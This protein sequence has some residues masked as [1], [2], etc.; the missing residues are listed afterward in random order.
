MTQGPLLTTTYLLGSEG[1]TTEPALSCMGLQSGRSPWPPTTGYGFPRTSEKGRQGLCCSLNLGPAPPARSQV[2][3]T[4]ELLQGS[5]R[6]PLTAAPDQAQE[7]VLGS[8]ILDT[9]MPSLLT[10]HRGVKGEQ[11]GLP[12]A[13][14]P[15]A[16][17][18]LTEE[19]ASSSLWSTGSSTLRQP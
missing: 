17:P 2:A 7:R 5:A 4:A 8:C 6:L 18:D 12:G 14:G 9:D 1:A 3:G 11:T 10:L 16:L 19:P 13:E 15:R